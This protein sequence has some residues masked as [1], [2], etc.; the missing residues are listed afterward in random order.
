MSKVHINSNGEPGICKAVSGAC[1]FGAADTHFSS[2]EEAAQAYESAQKAMG[3][4]IHQRVVKN[5]GTYEDDANFATFKSKEEALKVA[6]IIANE[7]QFAGV[8]TTTIT[9]SERPDEDDYDDEE[10]YVEASD[11]YE[12]A[13]HNHSVEASE[14]DV[15]Y[16]VRGFDK[17]ED[18]DKISPDAWAPYAKHMDEIDFDLD[19]EP[20]DVYEMDPT[21][22]YLNDRQWQTTL[23]FV[24]PKTKK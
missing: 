8:V 16:T 17:W 6:N 11:T 24:S 10:A 9:Y 7:G 13:F 14:T 21:D 12:E 20:S 3:N 23:E 1:P 18:R 5:D 19:G 4:G 2:T 15:M 22:D